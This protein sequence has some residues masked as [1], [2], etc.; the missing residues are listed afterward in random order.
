MRGGKLGL[1]RLAGKLVLQHRR[2]L[3]CMKKRGLKKPHAVLYP[4]SRRQ[5]R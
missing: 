4:T 1:L 3:A 5:A 2:E